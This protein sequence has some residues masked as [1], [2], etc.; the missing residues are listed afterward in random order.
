MKQLTLKHGGAE[1]Q[2]SVP[3]TLEEMP[4]SVLVGILTECELGEAK[5]EPQALIM[6]R[7]VMSAFELTEAEVMATTSDDLE[8]LY[9][10][11]MKPIMEYK[12]TMEHEVATVSHNGETY[13][14]PSCLVSGESDYRLTVNEYINLEEALRLSEAAK[15]PA[16]REYAET[17]DKDAAQKYINALFTEYCEILAVLLRRPGE[18]LP[19]DAGERDQFLAKR[20]MRFQDV[21]AKTAMDAAFFLS[22]RPNRYGKITDFTGILMRL[23]I[24]TITT[25]MHLKLQKGKQTPKGTG[26]SLE[27]A[28][29][30]S[31]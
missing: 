14:L 25:L 31:G 20:K 10:M 12:P 8:A 13:M 6:A 19:L 21:N 2:I 17:G 9:M 16:M 28:S 7:V 11:A 22:V 15:S 5:K 26:V 24:S 3:D 1:R 18:I 23:T 27:S 4:L 30:V 29:A